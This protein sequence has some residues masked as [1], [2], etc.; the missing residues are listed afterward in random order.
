MM[1]SLKPSQCFVL[2]FLSYL[3]QSKILRNVCNCI[4]FVFKAFLIFKYE[5]QL[6]FSFVY[7]H[8]W[9]N[10]NVQSHKAFWPYLIEKRLTQ[11]TSLKIKWLENFFWAPNLGIH[12]GIPAS[13]TPWIRPLENYVWIFLSDFLLQMFQNI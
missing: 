13:N 5:K 1:K 4:L 6:S 9:H 2:S 10:F 7:I 12:T 3:N 8:M 11:S